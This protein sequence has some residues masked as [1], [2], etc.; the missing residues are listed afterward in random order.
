MTFAFVVPQKGIHPYAVKSLSNAI[1]LLGHSEF[2]L[3]SDGEPSIVALKQAVKLERH[4][5][6]V[7]EESP[8]KESKSNGAIERAI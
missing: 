7:S 2:V 6:I 3:R 8:V 4:E 5:R 1:A